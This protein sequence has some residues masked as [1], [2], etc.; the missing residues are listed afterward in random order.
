[1]PETKLDIDTSICLD[2][3]ALTS[4]PFALGPVDGLTVRPLRRLAD[5]SLRSGLVRM[6]AGWTSGGP[7]TVRSTLQLAILAGRL[8]FGDAELGADAFVVVPAGHSLPDLEALVDTELL[9]VSDADQ[10]LERHGAGDGAIVVPDMFAIEPITPVV[11][12]RKLEGF[13]RRVLW[14]DPQTGA[15]TR[16]LKV[17]AGFRGMGASYHP[18]HE[19][20][21]CLAGDIEPDPSRPMRA[22][23]Y[24]WNPA[25]SVH[26][27][28]EL[29]RGGCT[30]IEW[31]DGPWSVEFYR[32][33]QAQETLEAS[34]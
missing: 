3:G 20:I 13:E 27:F 9:L 22:G 32:E 26:G 24:L 11:G 12:G 33:P 16:L 17:P 19:E 21:F 1:M 2:S 6:P 28:A 30:I 5:G 31:H 18:V 8:R 25:N 14:L 15:D 23:T 29:S 10:R 7:L 34:E 4:E